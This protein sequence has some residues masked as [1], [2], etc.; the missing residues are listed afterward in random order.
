LK[1]A[2]F[3]AAAMKAAYDITPVSVSA[4]NHSKSTRSQTNTNKRSRSSLDDPHATKRAKVVQFHPETN[5]NGLWATGRPL[6]KIRRQSTPFIHDE[7]EEGSVEFVGAQ[8]QPSSLASL[9]N[10][11]IVDWGEAGR[12]PWNPSPT[13]ARPSAGAESS[14][15][16]RFI[17]EV[18]AIF[19]TEASTI[20]HTTQVVACPPLSV[21]LTGETGEPSV[22]QVSDEVY[23]DVTAYLSLRMMK[24]LSTDGSDSA[25]AVSKGKGKAKAGL[26]DDLGG[27]GE[28]V[29]EGVR[30]SQRKHIHSSLQ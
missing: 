3:G 9:F 8:G 13:S 2:P 29:W 7:E 6:R 12:P 11:D 24:C 19:P 21:I 1:T 22:W 16:E 30:R 20:D 27:E 5:D 15:T 26:V 23:Q 4:T 28:V 18:A 10:D 14:S 25:S 17:G